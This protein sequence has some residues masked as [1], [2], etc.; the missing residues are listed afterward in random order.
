MYGAR[1]TISERKNFYRKAYTSGIYSLKK[2][3]EIYQDYETHFEGWEKS[4]QYRNFADGQLALLQVISE[5]KAGILQS[6]GS[7]SYGR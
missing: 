2:L 1:I 5:I 6:E 3:I 4:T 7:A